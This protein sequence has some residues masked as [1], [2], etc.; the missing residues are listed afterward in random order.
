[1][2]GQPEGLDDV[3]VSTNV[4][5]DGWAVGPETDP[6]HADGVEGQ[7]QRSW[8]VRDRVEVEPGDV[9]RRWFAQLDLT[10]R[11]QRRVVAQLVAEV[12]PVGD[13]ADTA[14]AMSAEQP[15]VGE[16]LD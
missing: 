12:E 8:P 15:E 7:A 13:H 9:V 1:M 16:S 10:P 14:A 2:L 5:R 3:E 11:S 4:E 6:L